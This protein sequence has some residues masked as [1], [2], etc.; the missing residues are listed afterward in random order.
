MS[1]EQPH[2][3]HSGQ[4]RAKLVSIELGYNTFSI[5]VKIVFIKYLHMKSFLAIPKDVKRLS[6]IYYTKV[7]QLCS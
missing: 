7:P 3:A 5:N 6:T 1:L 2:T 4:S